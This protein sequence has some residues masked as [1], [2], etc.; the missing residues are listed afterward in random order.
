M[1]L[2][3]PVGTAISEVPLSDREVATLVADLVLPKQK[4]VVAKGGRGGW[5]NVHFASSTNQTPQLAQGG[6]DG[7]ERK[8]LLEL[9][10]IAD[11][12]IVGYPNSGKS[13]LL[14]ATTAAHPKVASYPFTTL[15]PALGVFEDNN[16]NFVIA[17]VPGLI[18]DAHLGRGLGHDFLRHVA[19][20]RILIHLID[21]LSVSPAGDMAHVN[22]ELNLF[23]PVLARKQQ[24][25]AVSKLDLSQVRG[26]LPEIKATLNEVGHRPFF[27]SAISGEGVAEL[28]KEVAKVLHHLISQKR[29]TQQTVKKVFRP[30][31]KE[32]GVYACHQDG[33]LVVTAPDME[34]LVDGSD[35]SDAEV[36]RQLL[37]QFKR[38]GLPRAL[39]EASAKPGDR[40]RIGDYEWR[41]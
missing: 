5:G 38:M 1:I 24:L 15:E 13:S 27:V 32:A 12:G 39:E 10:L 33:V 19:R 29:E 41:L 7:E 23:D 34:R 17:E 18:R 26:R 25:V 21:G 14:S 37:A 36:Q 11:V 20:T 2:S 4:A 35:I 3:V 8:I 28:M 40:V 30:R 9:K 31:P 6:A 22:R 16:N